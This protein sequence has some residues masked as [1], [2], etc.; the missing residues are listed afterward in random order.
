MNIAVCVTLLWQ[1][2]K[3]YYIAE[4]WYNRALKWSFVSPV[5]PVKLFQIAPAYGNASML[6]YTLGTAY[7]LL[8]VPLLRIL[9]TCL[10]QIGEMCCRAVSTNLLQCQCLGQPALACSFTA[11]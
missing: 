6:D 10:A 2:S 4:T 8:C 9:D 7:N 5:F 11:P 3:W 1:N